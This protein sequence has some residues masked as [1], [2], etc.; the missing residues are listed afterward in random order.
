MSLPPSLPEKK[1]LVERRHYA[2]WLIEIHSLE[3]DGYQAKGFLNDKERFTV[4]GETIDGA[5]GC[6][7]KVIGELESLYKK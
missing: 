5:T 1:T 3:D 2:E 4:G 7:I 6:A